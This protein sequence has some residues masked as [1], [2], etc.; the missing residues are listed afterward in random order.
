MDREMYRSGPDGLMAFTQG[1]MSSTVQVALIAV[2][3]ALTTVAT[4]IVSVPFPTSTGYLNFGDALVMLSGFLLGPTGGFIAGGF[5]SAMGDVAL[6]YTHFAP[7]TFLVKG[8]E[9]AVVGMFCKKTIMT[10]RSTDRLARGFRASASFRA[11][12]LLGLVL[13]A[14]TMMI[15]YFLF[16]IPLYGFGA[17]LAEAVTVNWIQ[18][19]VGVMVTLIL[20]PSLRHYL[21][22]QMPSEA[23]HC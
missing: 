18:V 17:A 21:N 13:A 3:T 12:D 23:V 14:M 7:I 16:E 1:G 9:G 22:A 15:G 20:G 10:A 4:V 2:F 19:C 5:G 11:T 6:G 8:C